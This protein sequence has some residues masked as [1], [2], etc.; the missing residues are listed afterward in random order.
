M[1]SVTVKVS[2]KNQNEPIT[3]KSNSQLIERIENHIAKFL[4]K[5]KIPGLVIT[6][7]KG[8]DLHFSK[9]YGVKSLNNIGQEHNEYTVDTLTPI[10]SM[11][12][13]ITAAA[14]S[15][16]V[17]QGKL[18]W[19]KPLKTY[20]PD[21]EFSDPWVTDHVTILDLLTHRTGLTPAMD[22]IYG[23]NCLLESKEIF[24]K[25]LK[26]IPL[27]G[28]FRSSFIYNNMMYSLASY[29]VKLVS[30]TPFSHFVEE[31]IF[32]P[33]GITKFT[34]NTPSL[35]K[36]GD[37]AAPHEYAYTMEEFYNE[38][39]QSKKDD[40]IDFKYAEITGWVFED[41]ITIGAGTLS[42]SAID[43]MKWIKC[44]MND[45]KSADGTQVV[46][47]VELIRKPHNT[48]TFNSVGYG[49][50]LFT[51]LVDGHV[52]NFHTG[53]LP[54]IAG[55]FSFVKSKDI[56]IY[57][58]TNSGTPL[59]VQDVIL[60]E[61]LN[62]SDI[63]T[64]MKRVERFENPHL[65]IESVIEE[66]EK[67]NVGVKQIHPRFDEFV[68]TYTHPAYGEVVISKEDRPGHLSMVR[69]PEYYV[70]YPYSKK[71]SGDDQSSLSFYTLLDGLV[72]GSWFFRI[73]DDDSIALYVK[74]ASSVG[75]T[76][77]VFSKKA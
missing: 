73:N 31:H 27:I 51:K 11:T 45:G 44:L 1:S 13:S 41:E 66:Y 28:D 55:I 52:V 9:G 12:K 54:G 71:D 62:A 70:L 5:T 39:K 30:G 75:E 65:L 36:S 34:W 23:K 20:I 38:F 60:A 7:S 57:M 32:K 22:G 2:V 37:F 26:S 68:G 59:H 14:I 48:N 33:L 21:I 49:C 3:K 40:V 50:G 47:D 77:I 29:I 46:F 35:K 64:T 43:M 74:D 72:T 56:A 24:L 63:S 58:C 6:L 18:S 8:D 4:Q 25:N 61:L 53:G 16:L 10:C 19:N 76:E 17:N 67:L 69:Q 42:L 15:I